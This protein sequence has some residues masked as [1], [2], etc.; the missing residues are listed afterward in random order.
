[1]AVDEALDDFGIEGGPACGDPFY[2]VN[3]LGDVPHTILEQVADA[4][5]VVSDQLEHVGR[6]E[7]LREDEHRRARMRAP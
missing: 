1:M 3:E 5:G 6:L 2:R 4:R 7:V